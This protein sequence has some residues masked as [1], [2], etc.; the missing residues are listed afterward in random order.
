[1]CSIDS[2]MVLAVSIRSLL[3]MFKFSS[4]TL[5]SP[6]YSSRV[7]LVVTTAERVTLAHT[8]ASH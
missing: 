4:L 5:W 8:H 7:R 6:S 3:E 2:I 1:M